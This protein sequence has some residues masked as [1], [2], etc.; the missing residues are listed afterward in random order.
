MTTEQI[1]IQQI[2]EKYYSFLVDSYKAYSSSGKINISI[3]ELRF[4]IEQAKK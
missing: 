2:E 1:R 3:E 4:L